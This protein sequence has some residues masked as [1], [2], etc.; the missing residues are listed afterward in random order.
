[1][2][3]YCTYMYMCS[4]LF[5]QKE[6]RCVFSLCYITVESVLPQIKTVSAFL[7]ICVLIHF[8]TCTYAMS[9]NLIITHCKCYVQCTCTC[10]CTLCTMYIVCSLVCSLFSMYMYVFSIHSMCCALYMYMYAHACK[11]YCY[12]TASKC[13]CT[14]QS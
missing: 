4:I 6:M 9:M 11:L 3:I 7:E 5:L 1:M 14:T 2:Y 13:K 12:S 10:T 8:Y